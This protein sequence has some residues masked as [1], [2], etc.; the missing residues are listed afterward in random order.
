MQ[1][2]NKIHKILTH[3]EHISSSVYIGEISVYFDHQTGH[4]VAFF[5]KH[6]E[7]NEQRL[8]H[9]P[10]KQEYKARFFFIGNSRTE[11]LGLPYK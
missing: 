10:Y 1:T 6:A 9:K 7:F 8:V 4:I 2:L 5:G 3:K 11:K